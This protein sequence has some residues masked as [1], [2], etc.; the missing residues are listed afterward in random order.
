MKTNFFFISSL[1]LITTVGAAQST[2]PLNTVPSRIVGHPLPETLTVSTGNPNLVEG[3]EFYSPEGVALDTS[4]T[5]P[6]LYVSDP[7]N[8]RVLAWK[9]G[10]NWANNPKADLVIGQQD[11]Y[12]TGPQGPGG[13][14]PSG[15]SSP[16][17]IVTDNNGNLYVVDTL[18]NR[19]LR[20]PTPFQ[21]FAQTGSVFPDMWV[22]QPSLSTNSVNFGS[23]AVNDQ[24]LNLASS[25]F[26][27]NIALDSQ[28]NLWVVDAGNRR[29]LEFTAASLAQAQA[30]GF[31]GLHASLE[32]GQQD[33][34]SNNQPGPT[35]SSNLNIPNA[36]TTPVAI[37][38]DASGNL[39]V[40][41]YSTAVGMGR[42]LVFQPPFT[43]KQSALRIMGVP[44]STAPVAQVAMGLPSG[45]F[46]IPASQTI[47][48][49][50][51]GDSRI[52]LFDSFDSGKWPINVTNSPVARAVFGQTSYTNVV[53]NG[54]TGNYVP[55]PTASTFYHPTAV[56]Y[57]SAG[58][59]LFVADTLN[60]RVLTLPFTAGAL[61]AATQVLGQLNLTMSAPN[62]IEGREFDFYPNTSGS[63]ADA[64]VAI[65]TST[66]AT[67]P[68][69]YVSDP[70]NHRVLGFMDFRSLAA[71]SKADIVI[72]QLD[73]NS[74]SCNM[75]GNP[76]APTASSLCYPTGLAVDPN[77]NLYV[78]DSANSRVLRFP[79]PF[80]Y[81]GTGPEPADLVLGQRLFTLSIPEPTG[82][83]MSSPYGLA[84]TDHNGL[85]VSDIS[86]NRVLFFPF[87]SGTDTFQA[88]TDNGE[89]ATKVFGQQNFNGNTSGSGGNQFN[90]PH[91]ISADNEARLYVADSSNGRVMIFD[92]INGSLTPSTGAQAIF[93]ITGLS[94]PRSVFVNPVT[95]EIW[96]GDNTGA[97]KK[98]PIYQNLQVNPASTADVLVPSAALALT[99]DQYGDMIVADA[100]NRVGFYFPAADA[101]NGGNFL[102]SCIDGPASS[103]RPLAPGIL[104]SLCSQGSLCTPGF[105][106]VDVRAEHRRRQRRGK[107]IPAT[108][109]PGRYAGGHE[110]D[111]RGRFHHHGLDAALLCLADANQ[112]RGP[113]ECAAYRH[114]QCCRGAEFDGKDLRR[115]PGADG[116]GLARHPDARIHGKPAP[117]GG[118][119]SGGWHGQFHH[120]PGCPRLL[121]HHLRYRPGL[122]AGSARRRRLEYGRGFGAGRGARQ[123]QRHLPGPD[124]LRPVLGHPA[125]PMAGVL[126]A[127][128]VSR[129]VADQRLHSTRRGS[130][131]ADPAVH[132]G[133]R[134]SQHG[135]QHV[136][137][138]HQ[139]EVGRKPG[140][141]ARNVLHRRALLPGALALQRV[142]AAVGFVQ[143]IAQGA[144]LHV[145]GSP[146]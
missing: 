18:N 76:A 1:A 36:F 133:R 34:V 22:G 41:D 20:Y 52:L 25:P 78:A 55:A 117:G 124:G 113:D 132:H 45:L 141:T 64:G 39:F 7:G 109:H 67:A 42:V 75:T 48:V 19:I 12:H 74:G 95:S 2:I 30:S 15:M 35:T 123:H 111:Q 92:Q 140:L 47:G 85:L 5:P 43:N 101:I 3:R 108:H 29:V 16:N 26:P 83:T 58:Q 130:E 6:V 104:A 114:G 116:G 31:T 60:N 40:S 32:I 28:N 14:F 8:N 142:H 98:F 118:G 84:L 73:F 10:L 61:S 146:A 139:C 120:Q 38:F 33:F 127:V 80:A 136:R 72:G 99:Q 24:G 70:N 105:D 17:G 125:E 53:G 21:Q 91:H 112:F 4:V 89:P 134:R 100:T 145:R 126:G 59:M 79:A 44:Y 129:I 68:H 82:S 135:A 66:A 90:S 86:D 121:R 46:F 9:N 97:V 96:V 106:A 27:V 69:L 94:T 131:Q 107:P 81:Q 110:L 103:C 87:D 51:T 63:T 13:T 11:A 115:R 65:D 88:G 50:D 54:G 144:A 49:V 62:M 37:A 137:D 143:G 128:V 122:R 23:G 56:V 93:Q 57:D 77:G 102:P 138:V 71:G 119:E